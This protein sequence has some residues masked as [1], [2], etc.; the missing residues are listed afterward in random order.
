MDDR[1]LVERLQLSLDAWL[2]G[3]Y[4]STWVSRKLT[5]ESIAEITRLRAEARLSEKKGKDE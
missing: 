1:D 3:E 5:E 4:V 2:R